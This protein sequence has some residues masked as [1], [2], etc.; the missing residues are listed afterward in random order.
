M[1]ITSSLPGTGK[2]SV[3]LL[4]AKSLAV[5]GK[6]VLLVEGDLRRP[7]LAERMKL[8]TNE[9]LASVL[10]GGRDDREAILNSGLSNLDVLPA[11]SIPENFNTEL[12]AN[13][14]FENC[15]EAWKRRYDFVLID[16]PPLLPVADAQILAG[17]AEGTVMVLRSSHDRKKEAADAFAQLKAAGG[18]LIGTVLI[19]GRFSQ[20]DGDGYT[21]DYYYYKNPQTYRTSAED[22]GASVR[23][24]A[25]S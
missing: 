17:H 5:V 10:S 21:Y 9:G 20:R 6:K 18:N 16:S 7:T 2:T 13:G 24:S 4:L 23:D 12:L 1:L 19:G 25:S 11:G 22:K 14:V 3:S 15:V 8:T